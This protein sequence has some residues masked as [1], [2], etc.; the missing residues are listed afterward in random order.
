M[1]RDAH[2]KIEKFGTEYSGVRIHGDPKRPEVSQ[3]GIKFPGGE[4][5]VTRCTDGTYW[6]HVCTDRDNRTGQPTSR[7]IDERED[8]TRSGV[9]DHAAY[10]FEMI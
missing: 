10:K 1:K 6:A 4:I 9:F 7:L 8:K 2:L 5:Y 3:F